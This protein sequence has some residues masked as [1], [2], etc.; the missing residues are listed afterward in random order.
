M[1]QAINSSTTTS[2][3]VRD[4]ESL[5]VPIRVDQ[6]RSKARSGE[7]RHCQ[8]R[9]LCWKYFLHC[10][11]EQH[12]QWLESCAE[13]RRKYEDIK[14]KHSPAKQSSNQQQVS[15]PT[16][17]IEKTTIVRDNDDDNETTTPNFAQVEKDKSSPSSSLANILASQKRK[18]FEEEQQYIKAAN[19]C[20]HKNVFRTIERDVVRTFPDMEF[21]RQTEMQTILE[22]VLF[23]YASENPHLSY[24]QGMHELLATL[25]YVLHTDSQNCLINYEGGYANETIATLLDFKYLEHDV[26]HLFCALMKSIETWYQNDEILMLPSNTASPHVQRDKNGTPTINRSSNRQ[27]AGSVLGNKLKMISEN[28]VKNYD[29]ELFNHLE[30]LQIAPQIYG[31]RWMRLLFGREFEFLDLLTV[32]DAIICD[33]NSM[34]LTD[35]IFA[36]ML[37]TI[38][39]EL[40]NGDYTD[41]LNNL[42]RHQF[43]DVQY[44]IRLAL[45]LRDPLNNPRP[46]P[47]HIGTQK[48]F[49]QRNKH[50]SV[51]SLTSK[52]SQQYISGKQQ[53]GSRNYSLSQNVGTNSTAH[54]AGYP[55]RNPPKK[56]ASMNIDNRNSRNIFSMT[57]KI[58]PPNG[59]NRLDYQSNPISGT[60][61]SGIRFLNPTSRLPSQMSNS[62]SKNFLPNINKLVSSIG[63]NIQDKTNQSTSASSS[64]LKTQQ[65]SSSSSSHMPSNSERQQQQQPRRPTDPMLL[66]VSPIKEYEMR[67]MQSTSSSS[68][69]KQ[70]QSTKFPAGG[71]LTRNPLNLSF[72]SY[73]D[74]HGIVDY[75]WRLL[76]EQID[77]LQRCLPKEKSL[78]S[79]DEIF[80][81]LAQLKKVRDVLKG[82]LRLEDELE[83]SPG[84]SKT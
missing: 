82:S 5:F 53:T 22:N 7:L 60:E 55:R 17:I 76:S 3:Y 51:T 84:G 23:N 44:V 59:G 63:Q 46:K 20:D 71:S 67:E 61:S 26:F 77:S 64:R 6:L 45:Y 49:N 18:E 19:Q 34:S 70:G 66:T 54:E 33:H 15:T 40:V 27:Q 28:I 25:L 65:W 16:P 12:D 50:S 29:L 69:S 43:K 56:S 4:F 14:T 68:S 81:A 62:S 36:S 10:L 72:E 31:I 48:H 8:F 9:S 75:C 74:L 78:H 57:S 58:N 30:A 37:V 79:E 42:M 1:E 32:W 39:E 73:D 38:R 13:S 2:K 47:L 52:L 35:Y 80:V 11:P 24:K 83:P 41:C 21:F